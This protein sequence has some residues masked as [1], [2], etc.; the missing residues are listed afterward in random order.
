MGGRGT[1]TDRESVCERARRACVWGW[2]E[3]TEPANKTALS[4]SARYTLAANTELLI[5]D[6]EGKH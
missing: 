3:E 2:H 5:K 4:V 1:D 6:Q